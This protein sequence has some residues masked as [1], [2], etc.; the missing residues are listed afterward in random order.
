[1][2]LRAP[3]NL[4]AHLAH[5]TG[6]NNE[7]LPRPT[8]LLQEEHRRVLRRPRCGQQRGPQL[9][10]RLPQPLAG[11]QGG[12]FDARR[13]LH[14]LVQL[15]NLR[16]ERAHHLGD[17]T[18]RL[19]AH[20]PRSA[21]PRAARLPS[22]GV[23]FL[24]RVFGPA[25]EISADPRPPDGDVARGAQEPGSGAKPG[26]PSARIR[27]RPD[28]TSRCVARADSCAPTGRRSPK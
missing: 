12:A 11:R 9:G 16:Q 20:A 22:R 23:L 1:M 5:P 19:P 24:V 28:A 27:P 15:E 25:G 18:N 6:A 17:P 13:E 26:N 10:E 2:A 4:G 14:R 7:S 8:D 21:Q 3:L